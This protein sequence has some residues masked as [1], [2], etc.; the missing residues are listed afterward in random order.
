MVFGKRWVK[1]DDLS[2]Q[3]D[4]QLFGLTEEKLK[5][6]AKE[7]SQEDTER[8]EMEEEGGDLKI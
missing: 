3:Y 1:V 5:E 2:N 7:M 8:F 6:T 4:V